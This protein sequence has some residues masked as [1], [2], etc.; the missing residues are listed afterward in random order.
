MFPLNKISK[1]KPRPE[2]HTK[3]NVPFMLIGYEMIIANSATTHLI[4]YFPPHSQC[5]LME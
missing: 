3:T 5:A 1:E 2:V 4:G